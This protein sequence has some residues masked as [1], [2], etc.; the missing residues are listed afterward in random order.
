M[1]AHRGDLALIPASRDRRSGDLTTIWKLVKVVTAP[2][3]AVNKVKWKSEP[4]FALQC[5]PGAFFLL[6][7]D[8]FTVPVKE[9]LAKI[10]DT[11]DSVEAAREALK[12]FRKLSGTTPT[13]VYVDDVT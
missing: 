7:A 11:F 10:P 6:P 3:G 5:W 1:K 2:H 9:V 4:T 13:A 8:R 12:K